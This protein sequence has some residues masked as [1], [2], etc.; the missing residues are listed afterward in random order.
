MEQHDD[1]G[2]TNFGHEEEA[3]APSMRRE[4]G[5]NLTLLITGSVFFIFGLLIFVLYFDA[6]I[7]TSNL[8]PVAFFTVVAGGVLVNLC[9]WL[10]IRRWK[11]SFASI[12][13]LDLGEEEKARERD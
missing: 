11:R 6:N 9:L 8:F 13:D 5:K 2:E 1:E 3:E 7:D 4:L 12:P 10:A